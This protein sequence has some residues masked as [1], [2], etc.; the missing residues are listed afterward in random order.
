M[1][2]S[3]SVERDDVNLKFQDTEEPAIPWQME[4]IIVVVFAKKLCKYLGRGHGVKSTFTP[5]EHLTLLVLRKIKLKAQ[6]MVSGR[7]YEIC[8][9][10]RMNIHEAIS[11][12]S[13][14]SYSVR[15]CG[16]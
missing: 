12:Q 2:P 7:K 13:L 1:A 5:A 6:T 16:T 15:Q 9:E 10:I 3:I 4:L 8:P 11:Q 14:E